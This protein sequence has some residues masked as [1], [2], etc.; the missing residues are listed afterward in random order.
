M[1]ATSNAPA[2]APEKAS[3]FEDFIDIFASP[4]KV[5]ARR[6]NGSFGMQLLIVSVIA[7]LFFFAGRSVMSQIFDAEFSRRAA[8]AMAKNP[9][10]TQDMMNSQRNV[11]EKMTTFGAYV[12]TP[13]IVLVMGV[14]LWLSAM[15]AQAKIR[16]AQAA[17]IITLAWVPRLVGSVI[18]TLLIV[19]T[20]T[21][22]ITSP[23]Q[24]TFSPARFMNPDTGNQK[25]IAILG[26]FDVFTL[27]YTVLIGI[28][29]S[30]M[31]KVPRSKG[32]IAAAVL[33][34]ITMLPAFF[35]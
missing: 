9:R 31:A 18:T 19:L 22:N 12:A 25:L 28:G 6:A 10:I 34:I 35:R 16:Y 15:I 30:V 13:I 5:F 29:V 27:W 8:E 32:Y 1:E 33:F 2:T 17:T 11:M 23:A 7:A 21:S 4:A 24:L 14:L 3:V 26:N 20:D